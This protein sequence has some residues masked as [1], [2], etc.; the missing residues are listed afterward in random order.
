MAARERSDWLSVM[1]TFTT[2]IVL[3]GVLVTAAPA[4]A[5][6]DLTAYRVRIADHPAYVRVVVDFTDGR[7]GRNDSEAVD[8]DP[9]DGSAVVDVSHRRV[10]AQA[11][12]LTAEGV[13]VR[14]IQKTNRI[15][16]RVTAAARRLK[17]LARTQLRDPERLV[18]DL[19]KSRPPSDAAQIPAA[20]DGCLEFRNAIPEPGRIRVS[21][22]ARN[23]FENQFT[24]NVRGRGGRIRGTRHVLFGESGNWTRVVRYSVDRRQAGTLEAVD[25]SERD[26]TLACLAQ[27]RMPLR[28]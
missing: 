2:V 5:T 19:Y 21:G 10:Q 13:R 7:M 4:A 17:Y 18:L 14:V 20:P 3:A 27:V 23:I 28:P 6:V 8:A 15:R 12:T 26:G 9:F 22:R 25:L 11:P 16:V 1:K 24:L